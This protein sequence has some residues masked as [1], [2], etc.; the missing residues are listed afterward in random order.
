MKKKKIIQI[1]L[2]I[3]LVLILM[4]LDVWH[5]NHEIQKSYA[6]GA[7]DQYAK[8][9]KLPRKYMKELKASYNIKSNFWEANVEIY[10]NGKPYLLEYE[11]NQYDVKQNKPNILY[12]IYK[13]QGEGWGELLHENKF[14]YKPLYEY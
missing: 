9:Q 7:I 1:A 13:K 14:R 10:V 6:Q 5:Q 12:S 2:I 3:I 8:V 11:I 4:A